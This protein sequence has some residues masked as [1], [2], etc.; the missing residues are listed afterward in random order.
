MCEYVT[1]DG[2]IYHPWWAKTSPWV[3]VWVDLLDGNALVGLGVVGGRGMVREREEPFPGFETG[4]GI[5]T[6][7]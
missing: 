1:S 5:H 2:R 4:F 6:Q 3:E 7:G